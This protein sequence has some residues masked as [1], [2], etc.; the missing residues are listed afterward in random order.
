VETLEPWFNDKMVAKMKDGR[1]IEMS[2]RRSKQFRDR[3][4][5]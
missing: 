2:R 4:K 1:E 3:M 5:L